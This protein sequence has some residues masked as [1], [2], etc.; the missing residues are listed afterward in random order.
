MVAELLGNIQEFLMFFVP[1][2]IFLLKRRSVCSYK[3]DSDI[4]LVIKS[5]G[6][7]AIIKLISGIL[8][9]LIK[10]NRFK[11]SDFVRFYSDELIIIFYIFISYLLF[12]VVTYFEYKFNNSYKEK[13]IKYFKNK[14][15]FFHFLLSKLLYRQ[16]ESSVWNHILNN[17]YNKQI[18][19]YIKD[20][21]VVYMGFL[22]Y[23]T[24][25]SEEEVKEICLNKFTIVEEV[26]EWKGNEDIFKEK[27][28][29]FENE[30]SF[31][32]ITSDNIQRIEILD[33]N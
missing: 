30:N 8:F 6:I 33:V 2:Y 25:D 5:I 12:Y 22:K 3:K 31:V 11:E 15:N 4:D 18:R 32:Y 1:G 14:T 9:F 13:L 7:S 27:D 23:Y 29:F 19:I 17:S 21:S 28:C 16:N 10:E 20:T 26:S 24:L